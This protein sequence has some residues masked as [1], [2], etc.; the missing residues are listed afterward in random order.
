MDL[1]AARAGGARC[2]RAHAGPSEPTA[3]RGAHSRSTRSNR[4][5]N[6]HRHAAARERIE[7][8]IREIDKCIRLLEK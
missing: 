1:P 5:G 6:A 4:N 8:L 2:D 7:K 3:E